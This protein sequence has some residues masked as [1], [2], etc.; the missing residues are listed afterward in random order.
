MAVDLTIGPWDRLARLA[1]PDTNTTDL[2]SAANRWA[3]NA[4]V[5]NAAADLWEDATM[6]IDSAP[7]ETEQDTERVVNRVSQDGITVEYA[8]DALAGNN[9]SSRIAQRAQ[10]LATVRRLRARGKPT[11]PKVHDTDYDPWRNV[12]QPDDCEIIVVVDGV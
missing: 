2:Q 3:L 10:M 8:T 11:S 5:Y 9:Q 1:P 7:D 6:L 12:P 4:D